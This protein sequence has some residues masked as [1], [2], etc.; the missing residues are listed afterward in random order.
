LSAIIGWDDNTHLGR[1]NTLLSTLKKHRSTLAWQQFEHGL[2][3]NDSLMTPLD[4]SLCENVNFST[5]LHL[6]F[7]KIVP[8]FT[9]SR[10]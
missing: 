6:I 2:L 4:A 8:R 1:H 3:L 7:S 10:N 9:I 5:A